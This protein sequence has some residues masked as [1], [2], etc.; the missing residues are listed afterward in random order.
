MSSFYVRYH[1]QNPTANI[2][3]IICYRCK[4]VIHITFE[5]R[6]DF[7]KLR[8][9]KTKC[10]VWAL[11]PTESHFTDSGT[12]SANNKT[13]SAEYNETFFHMETF[14]QRICFVRYVTVIF[15]VVERAAQSFQ[16]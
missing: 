8:S 10:S 1:D 13:L 15:N 2:E 9:S 11:P 14:R 12:F 7:V 5:L 3:I 16:N 6:V 4:Y